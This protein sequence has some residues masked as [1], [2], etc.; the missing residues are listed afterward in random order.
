MDQDVYVGKWRKVHLLRSLSGTTPPI[1]TFLDLPLHFQKGEIS[2]GVGFEPSFT[3]LSYAFTVALRRANLSIRNPNPVVQPPKKEKSLPWW[4]EMRNYIHGN[5]TL[6]FSETKWNIL[7]TTDPYENL[8]KLYVVSG[9]LEIQQSDGRIYASAKDFKSIALSLRWNFSLR[10]TL[11][12]NSHQPQSSSTNDQVVL[13]GVACSPLKPENARNDSPTVNLG[14]HD[15]AWLIKFWN[16]NYLPP[17]KLRTFSRWPRFGVPRIPRSGNLALDKVMTEFML[18]IDATPTCIRHVPLHDDDPAKG[19]TFN[20]TKEEVPP[21]IHG[22]VMSDK[23]SS[24]QNTTERH[25]DDGFFLSSDYFTIRRQSPRADAARLLAWQEAGRRNLEMTYVRSEFENGSES[26][27]HTRS[28]P[29]DDDGYNVVIADNCQRIF[30]YGLKLLWTLENRDAV[31]SWVGGLSKAFAPP[32]P[33]PSRVYAQRKLLEEKNVLD[34]PDDQKD[35][36]QNSSSVVDGASSSSQNVETS[37]PLS[38]PSSQNVETSKSLSSPSQ[39]VETSKISLF[40]RHQN[41]YLLLLRMWRHQS[42][43]LLLPIMWRHQNLYLPSSQNVE[44]SKSISSLPSSDTVENPSSSA[45]GSYILWESKL[46]RFELDSSS[47]NE[48]YQSQTRNKEF[49]YNDARKTCLSDCDR[50]R[51]CPSCHGGTWAEAIT[52]LMAWWGQE[53][54]GRIRERKGESGKGEEQPMWPAVVVV[55]REA[56]VNSGGLWYELLKGKAEVRTDEWVS[57][58]AKSS[59]IDDPEEEGTRHFMVNVIEPQFNLHSEEANLSASVRSRVLQFLKLQ[60]FFMLAI[61]IEQA[62]TGEKIQIPESQ[63]EMT[64]NRMEFSVMLE[65]VQAHVAPTDV[66]PGAGLQWLPKIRRSSPKVKRTGALLERVFMPCD[67]YFRYTRHKGG[68]SDLKVKPLKEL[69]FNS[70]NI[71]AS[72]TSRQFQVMLDVL[73]NLLFARLPKPRRNSLSYSA[74]DDEDVEEEADEVVPDGVEEV[75]LAKVNLEQKERVQKVI[76][77][78]IRKLSMRA[79]ISG[80]QNQEMEMDLWMITCGRSILITLD[81]AAHLAP[82]WISSWPVLTLSWHVLPPVNAPASLTPNGSEVT[83]AGTQ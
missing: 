74:E 9:Y 30:V 37:K 27:D 17:L 82:E 70:H 46:L 81:G 15:L 39:S 26:D 44:T 80:D 12:S 83:D 32:K 48:N 36:T 35:D 42:L 25:Q 68:T 54:W 57:V 53:R 77:D 61:E 31:W 8:D 45:I 24:T 58:R 47:G 28:D 19:L 59:N 21:C 16:L 63:P 2:F 72:M 78:D 69:T 66:D 14:P 22:K 18:R 33:S 20:M 41:L 51:C 13:D 55:E 75:E 43:R 29:S 11:P 40:W 5:T 50:G 1:K 62:L 65:H 6:C 4:D 23:N 49:K 10:P 71:T 76:L 56:A 73:T 79:D 3:D 38:S 52:S 60:K 67:M 34:R 7:A 64:W